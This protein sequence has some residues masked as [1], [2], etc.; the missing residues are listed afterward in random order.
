MRLTKVFQHDT[1]HDDGVWSTAWIADRDGFASG[2]VDESVKVWE[3]SGSDSDK[4]TLYTARHTYTGHT[5]GVISVAADSTGKYMA[6]SALDS[7]VRVWNVQTNQDVG[8]SVSSPTE[9]WSIAFG[10]TME[11]TPT[12]AVAGGTRASVTYQTCNPAVSQDDPESLG[13]MEKA[14][15]QLPQV[16]TRRCFVSRACL[17]FA[18]GRWML[19]LVVCSSCSARRCR[20]RAARRSAL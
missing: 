7:I 4:G 15:Y 13:L 18:F 16:I 17:P 11:D 9:V 20:W 2:S 10:P 1:A 5:L 14:V 6:S 3:G 19:A 12:L 8:V